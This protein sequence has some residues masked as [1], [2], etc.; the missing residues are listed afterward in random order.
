MNQYGG[1]K[2]GALD[3][4]SMAE[5][6]IIV[7]NIN[8]SGDNE[9][10][11][12]SSH[13]IDEIIDG[14]QENDEELLHEGGFEE[15]WE[16]RDE[17]KTLYSKGYD[18]R[19]E[20]DPEFVKTLQSDP[21]KSLIGSSLFPEGIERTFMNHWYAFKALSSHGTMDELFKMD[22]DGYLQDIGFQ[23]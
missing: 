22:N 15:E 14:L 1:Q 17:I 11:K 7:Y 9:Y 20:S 3:T 6:L 10:L 4:A 23:G 19:V 16:W 21:I 2:G 18:D 5:H 8:R 13:G 12:L